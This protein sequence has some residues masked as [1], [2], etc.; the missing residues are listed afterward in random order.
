[1]G[2]SKWHNKMNQVIFQKFFETVSTLILDIY[3]HLLNLTF[4]IFRNWAAALKVSCGEKWRL[5]QNAIDNFFY[6]FSNIVTEYADK[7]LNK[8]MVYLRPPRDK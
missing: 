1:V 5:G 3:V 8:N 7:V 6:I 4:H 2:L